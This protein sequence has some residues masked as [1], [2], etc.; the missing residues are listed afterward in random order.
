MLIHHTLTHR[1]MMSQK[2]RGSE[3][4][5][6]PL[7][8]SIP[9]LSEAHN[10]WKQNCSNLRVNEKNSPVLNLVHGRSSFW[11]AKH[12]NCYLLHSTSHRH[13]HIPGSIVRMHGWNGCTVSIPNT[14]INFSVK[15]ETSKQMILTCYVWE[16]FLQSYPLAITS[17]NTLS[18][19]RTQCNN[20]H[21]QGRVNL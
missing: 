1:P 14:R 6:W 4:V 8:T 10:F 13:R 7:K 9:F 5:V 17:K 20:V 15:D 3:I 21:L 12:N 11:V 18:Y 2:K 16:N 19:L